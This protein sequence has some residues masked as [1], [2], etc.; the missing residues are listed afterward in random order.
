[1]ILEKYGESSGYKANVHKTQLVTLNYK[2]LKQLCEKFPLKG[3]AFS[4][5]FGHL[6][7]KRHLSIDRS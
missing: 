3:S 7:A 6:F 2:P 4:E 5:M 1:M